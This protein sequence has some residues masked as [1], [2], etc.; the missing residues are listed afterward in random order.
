[1]HGDVS[2]VGDWIVAPC[3]CVDKSSQV[4]RCY[5]LLVLSMIAGGVCTASGCLAGF[6]V[7]AKYV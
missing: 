6:D 4:A 7:P 1:M 2:P 3:L 5:Y